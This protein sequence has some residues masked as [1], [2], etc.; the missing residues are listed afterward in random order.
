MT[1]TWVSGVH[2]LSE[3]VG[4]HHRRVG[5]SGSPNTPRIA[6]YPDAQHDEDIRDRDRIVA[7]KNY[8]SIFS[9]HR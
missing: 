9:Y 7:V 5:R 3:V 8:D 2:K 4:S 1:L 6:N